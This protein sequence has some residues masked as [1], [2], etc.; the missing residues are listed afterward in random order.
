MRVSNARGWC[1]L[2]AE[3]TAEIKEGV[4]AT[5]T[6]WWPT[7]SPDHQNINQTTSDRL[8]DFGGGSTFYTNLVYVESCEL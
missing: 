5:T 2:V 8:A 6:V 7:F 1:R 3:V 4:L